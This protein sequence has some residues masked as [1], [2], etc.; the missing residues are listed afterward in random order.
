MIAGLAWVAAGLAVVALALRDFAIE[1]R[2][3]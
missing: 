3:G 1:C 2:G